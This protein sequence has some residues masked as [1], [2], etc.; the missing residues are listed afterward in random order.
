VRMVEM[1]VIPE[2]YPAK[3]A[4]PKVSMK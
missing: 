3:A 1:D 4:M 2:K